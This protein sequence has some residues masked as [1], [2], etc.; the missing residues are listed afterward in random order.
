[1]T[2]NA[3][4]PSA[5]PG[6][7]RAL[8]GDFSSGVTATG[9]RARRGPGHAITIALIVALVVAVGV[10]LV[11][12]TASS[13]YD[14][15]RAAYDAAST[16]ERS[17]AARLDAAQKEAD[18]LVPVASRVGASGDEALVTSEE[19]VSVNDA[20]AR[21]TELRAE[22]GRLRPSPTA[23][24]GARPL[25][26]WELAAEAARLDH[27]AG[28]R[29]KNAQSIRDRGDALKAAVEAL[30]MSVS[31]AVITVSERATTLEARF[32]SARTGDV[33]ALRKA[34][35]ALARSATEVGQDTA[36]A[37]T[38]LESAVAR[39]RVS[40]EAELAE[41]A[42]PLMPTRLEIEDFARSIAG[43]VLLDFDWA[44]VVNGFGGADG[45]GGLTSWNAGDGAGGFAT[46][47]LSNSVAEIWPA[48]SSRALVVHEVG[49]AISAKCHALFDWKDRAANESWATAWAIGK[50][51]TEDANGVWLYGHPPQTLVDTAAT[52]R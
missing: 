43:G 19:R 6:G 52:C 34:A 3:P 51:E 41:K 36:T 5:L 11:Q 10:G 35:A 33:I 45:I 9:R 16:Q 50:G 42:G 39:V 22:A 28:A 29:E 48:D 4:P 49:H 15:S 46:I 24:T 47:T 1:M 44:P 26:P 14:D 8:P 25:V 38:S 31:S 21:V 20:S 37:F 40:H 13:A 23:D 12:V 30:R 32:V 27:E 18:A 7:R 2:D 17:S